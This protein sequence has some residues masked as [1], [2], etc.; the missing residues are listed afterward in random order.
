MN[1]HPA[2]SIFIKT[3]IAM[4]NAHLPPHKFALTV[5]QWTSAN[6]FGYRL[7]SSTWRDI[8]VGFRHDGFIVGTDTLE[9]KELF[10][11]PFRIGSVTR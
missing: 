2:D 10:R 7:M 6:A 3:A 1:L 4:A 11:V 9:M 8:D 5:V